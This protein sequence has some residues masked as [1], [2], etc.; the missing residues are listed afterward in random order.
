MCIFIKEYPELMA[1]LKISDVPK[2][3]TGSV[4]FNFE[5]Q[6]KT[7]MEPHL[8]KILTASALNFYQNH[9][10]SCQ[11]VKLKREGKNRDILLMLE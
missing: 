7:A 8:S 3:T 4:L 2:I 1:S 9:S 5:T 10:E 6:N 11:S